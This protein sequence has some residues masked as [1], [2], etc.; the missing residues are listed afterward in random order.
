MLNKRRL[1]F[2]RDT[3]SWIFQYVVPSCFVVLGM[4][5]MRVN[6]SGRE[7]RKEIRENKRKGQK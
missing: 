6:I 4:L 7:G 5:I 3:R 1:Y 2:L